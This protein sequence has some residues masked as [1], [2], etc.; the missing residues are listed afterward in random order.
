MLGISEHRTLLAHQ[1]RG[2]LHED[3][4]LAA[5]DLDFAPIRHN[6]SY[7]ETISRTD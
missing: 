2:S 4:V 7:T 1:F 5:N 6:S 3:G